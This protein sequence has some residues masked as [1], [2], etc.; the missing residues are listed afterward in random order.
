MRAKKTSTAWLMIFT[1]IGIGLAIAPTLRADIVGFNGGANY[2]TLSSPDAATQGMPAFVDT[3]VLHMTNAGTVLAPTG[4]QGTAVWYNTPQDM[5]TFQASFDYTLLDYTT[6]VPADGIV[7]VLQNDGLNAMGTTGG[8]RGYNGTLDPFDPL[9]T[10]AGFAFN[11]YPYAAGASGSDVQVAATGNFEAFQATA[12]VNLA[13]GNTIRT[14]ITFNGTNAYLDLEDL[15]TGDTFSTMGDASDLPLLF[16]GGTAYV[17]FTGGTGG[18]NALQEITNFTYAKAPILT[19]NGTALG[20]WT[21]PAWLGAPPTYPDINTIANIPSGV[22]SV[23]TA[24][25]S[26]FL[27]EVTGGGVS[28]ADD[29]SLTV[30]HT[31]NFASATSLSLG[32]R[33]AVNVAQGLTLAPDATLQIGNDATVTAAS[34]TLGAVT[35]LG[36]ATINTSAGLSATSLTAAAGTITK[37]GAGTLSLDDS[38]GSGISAAGTTF[39]VAEGELRSTGPA[40]L[41]GS[42]QVNLAGGMLTIDGGAFGDPGDITGFGDGSSFQL[43]RAASTPPEIPAITAGTLQLTSAINDQAASAFYTTPQDVT[44][45]TYEFDYQMAGFSGG[46][47]ADGMVMVFHNSPSAEFAIGGAGG[48]I[49]YSGITP[50]TGLVFNIYEPNVRGYGLLSNGT[51]TTPFQATG[52]L[53]LASTNVI[54][55]TV[56]YDGT[57]LR[58]DSQDTVTGATSSASWAVDIQ[59]QVGGS[60]AYVGFT[61]ATGGENADQF[62]SNFTNALASY[63]I[64]LQTTA[65]SVSAP[66]TLNAITDGTALFGPLTLEDGGVLTTMGAEKGGI[67]FASTT[68]AFGATSVGLD[69]RVPT[70][71][72]TINANNAPVE[73]AKVGPGTWTLGVQPDNL[74]ASAS[75]RVDDGMLELEGTTPMGGLPVTINGGTLTMI[76]GEKL[77]GAP[78]TLAGGRLQIGDG[79]GGIPG[80]IAGF[81]DGSN[82]TLNRNVET[83]EGV[84]GIDPVTSVLEITTAANSQATS[85]FYNDPQDIRAFHVEFDYQL[86]DGTADP[87]DGAALVVQNNAAGLNALGGGGGSRGYGGMSDSAAVLLNLWQARSDLDLGTNGA[88][89]D[90][91]PTSPVSLLSGNVIHTSVIYDGYNVNVALEDLTT[92]ATYSTM[93]T[94]VDIPTLVGSDMAYIGFSGGTGGANATQHISNFTNQ[95]SSVPVNTAG[96]DITVLE[97]SV[98]E[99]NTHTAAPFG[100]LTMV[101]G[102]LT[103]TGAFAGGMSFTSTEIDPGATAVG[104]NPMAP[105]DYGTINANLAEV[106]ISKTGS[107]TWMLPAAPLNMENAR[108]K[109]EDGTF[110]PASVATLAGR[111][112]ELAGGVFSLEGPAASGT[113]ENAL[114]EQ[115]YNQPLLDEAGLNA[116]LDPIGSGT[117]LLTTTPGATTVL[118]TGLNYQ[119]DESNARSGGVTGADDFA[120]VWRG[121]L[122][123]GA[124]PLVPAGEFTLASASDDGSVV[125]I[126]LNDDGVFTSPDELIVD[127]KGLHGTQVRVGHANLAEGDYEVL[128][129]FYERGGGDVME[130][131]GLPGWTNPADQAAVDA[132]WGNMIEIN[133]GD[134]LQ[135]GLWSTG[136]MVVDYRD[137]LD[138]SSVELTVTGDSTLAPVTD[139]SAVFGPLTMVNGTLTTSG[140]PLGITMASTAIDPAAT[141]IGFNPQVT[142]QLS[143][144]DGQGTSA[145]ISKYGGGDLVLDQE[146]VNLEAATF[147]AVGGRLIGVPSAVAKAN[148]FNAAGLRISGGEIVLAARN[149]GEDVTYYDAVTVEANGVLTGG[150]GGFGVG[151]PGPVTVTVGSAAKPLT[152]N[153]A[154]L[155]L[156]STDDYTLNVG[157]PIA[158]PGGVEVVGGQVNFSG[159]GSATELTLVGG[160]ATLSANLGA[161]VMTLDGGTADTGAHRFDVS[162]NLR[163]APNTFYADGT[164]TFGVTG[165]DLGTEQDLVLNGGVLRIQADYIG[166]DIYGFGDGSEYTFSGSAN[167]IAEDE[168]QIC[169]DF[170]Q[171]GNVFFNTKQDV[172]NFRAEFDYSMVAHSGT[173]ADEWSFIIQ[174]NAAGPA[175]TGSRGYGG[176]TESV[177]VRFNFWNTS[178]VHLGTN[179]ALDAGQPTA[180]IDVRLTNPIHMVMDYHEGTLVVG[181]EDLVTAQTFSTSYVIDIAT[182]I[183]A[184]D[185]LGYFGF[186]GGTGG[187]WADLRVTNFTNALNPAPIVAESANFLVVSDSTIELAHG[188]TTLGDLYIEDGVTVTL[189]GAAP[190]FANVSGGAVASIVGDVLVRDTLSPGGSVGTLNVNGSLELSDDATYLC[191]LSQSGNDLATATGDIWLAGTLS[192]KALSMVP[193]ASPDPDSPKPGPWGDSSV[194]IMSVSD[195]GEP[196]IGWWFEYEPAAGDHVG[197]GVFATDGGAN[198]QPVTYNEKSVVVDILQAAPG[199]T[200]GSRF[201]NGIDI[202]NI[203]AANKFGRLDVVADW[204]EGDFDGN[205]LVNG[206]DIQAILAANLFGMQDPY[207]AMDPGKSADGG[208]VSL[209]VVPG[210]GVYLDTKGVS[211]NSYVL[212]SDSSVFTGEPA[213]NLGLFT[214]DTDG[215]VSGGWGF[216]LNGVHFLGDILG[217]D[218]SQ[219]VDLL[220]DLGM[221]YTIDNA[222]GTFTANLIVVPEP[223]TLALLA[224]GLL[225]L[226]LLWRRRRRAA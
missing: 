138:A 125:Y 23:G 159:G 217:S 1:V 180:P 121:T 213:D 152:V 187:A 123:I 127:N 188:E 50:S 111:P 83:P 52:N 30:G 8:A 10:S 161:G 154:T 59:G 58:V 208:E 196:A 105:T 19:W 192:L 76:G 130:V 72:G 18:A 135:A 177:G 47:P 162:D 107:S 194:T 218:G 131:R 143:V 86:I 182:T 87:A 134:P 118:T 73:I 222:K 202:Q 219:A 42:T 65:I 197:Y 144:I 84:P 113:L 195:V 39:V 156:R 116:L 6:D 106:V 153:N 63:A 93:Y 54:H 183:G 28:V 158:G 104:F 128:A 204:T 75:W 189:T 117:G 36:N 74:S 90:R 34:G 27:L 103:T 7:F 157:G 133:P 136:D 178:D 145:V 148:P 209:V 173:P 45:F 71:Y 9:V 170:S 139:L 176:M 43:N 82:F 221:T 171:T 205:Q 226:G 77:G 108:W 147:N 66:S 165:A 190:A 142:T 124:N 223:G 91:R 88:I 89:G 85:A 137:S 168:L 41:G 3:E 216:A 102:N 160:Q 40:P 198:G 215:R 53:D 99:A 193:P 79:G 5:S 214:E 112:V 122:H 98:L 61:G 185:G 181:M 46:Q 110:Q 167:L 109:V 97:S 44:A 11:I 35:T 92:G 129:A 2:T 220:Q 37:L 225:A 31:A 94:G 56:R 100:A 141:A 48:G 166:G 206:L 191:E 224:S 64:D 210:E 24:D 174:N 96:I 169:Y 119:T 172:N 38:T 140:A 175:A 95:F 33:A 203:L 29:L 57:T 132:L 68:I 115:W 186:G 26:A 67:S 25:A 80:D 155:Q 78:V 4:N 51:V 164:N 200:D 149:T 151:A 114:V 17:G 146:N 32:A 120:A 20:D 15:T 211:I 212:T 49:G 60:T 199:D 12:P 22:V 179:G 201:V 101:N 13:S 70:N 150:T 69:P 62:I 126:D 81:G 184:T 21:V 14:T 55:N 207:A 163:V 16:P